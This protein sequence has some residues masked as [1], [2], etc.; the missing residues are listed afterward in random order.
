MLYLVEV[1]LH[2]SIEERDLVKEYY[3]KHERE[4]LFGFRVYVTYRYQAEVK[5]FILSCREIKEIPL[6]LSPIDRL[7]DVD[8]SFFSS[9]SKEL[10]EKTA[11]YYKV[12]KHSLMLLVAPFLRKKSVVDY[13]KLSYEAVVPGPKE[14]LPAAEYKVLAKIKEKGFVS[15]LDF[16][17]KTVVERLIKKGF[18]KKSIKETLIGTD[19][20]I[21]SYGLSE[22][23]KRAVKELKEATKPI[24]LFKTDSLSERIDVLIDVIKAELEEGRSILYLFPYLSSQS[25]ILSLFMETYNDKLV[26]FDSNI[27][28]N[29]YEKKSKAIMD[30]SGLIVLATKRGAFLNIKN[31][32]LI[33]IDE[34]ESVA[35]KNRE[36]PKIDFKKVCLLRGIK[37]ILCSS[38]FS[39]ESM[40]RYQRGYYNLVD[41][42]KKEP[43]SYKILDLNES[44]KLV[45]PSLMITLEL[46]EAINKTIAKGK[47]VLIYYPRRGY[48]TN[49]RCNVCLKDARCPN[50][51]NLLTYYKDSERLFCLSCGYKRTVKENR[52]YSCGSTDFMPLGYGTMRLVDD[53]E[54]IFKS[55]R[56]SRLDYDSINEQDYADNYSMFAL[57]ESDILVGTRMIAS[58]Y[59]FTN[60]GLVAAIDIDNYLLSKSYCAEEETYHL[61]SSLLSKLD[62]D[63]REAYIL[64]RY[65]DNP[66]IVMLAKQNYEEFYDYTMEKRRLTNDPPYVFLVKISLFANSNLE[67]GA[68]GLK[69]REL[70][71]ERLSF[72]R[73]VV[74]GPQNISGH[75]KN[76]KSTSK[77]ILKYKKRE[78]I[79]ELLTEL[80]TIKLPSQARLEIDIDPLGE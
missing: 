48:A 73:V 70:L 47:Q 50:C 58:T 51:G 55:S 30:L 31:L 19:R 52:C 36:D 80:L 53:L 76:A 27:S 38:S 24:V 17:H 15:V 77:I 16:G 62:K 25:P 45:A 59:N 2:D 6:D 63:S 4:P 39:I 3:L 22:E 79:D 32:S 10:I 33:I 61:L 40:A 41:L 34:E 13:G 68:L 18:V 71:L 9:D 26:I 35:Y 74:I 78:D 72:K 7:V 66:S 14:L 67:V 23:E 29:E 42:S 21:K 28:A 57:K 56:I 54:K 20:P 1:L 5:G 43:L 75:Q 11:W 60:I 37:S 44:D 12:S 64:T 46:K 49:F 8:Y 65:K 69:L